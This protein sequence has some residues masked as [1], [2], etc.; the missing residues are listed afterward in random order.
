MYNC[1]EDEGQGIVSMHQFIYVELLLEFLRKMRTK[2]EISHNLSLPAQL[3]TSILQ[4]GTKSSTINIKILAF[5][6]TV[7]RKEP[8]TYQDRGCSS[9]GDLQWKDPGIEA[10]A[11]VHAEVGSDA[12]GDDDQARVPGVDGGV[13]PD[14]EVEERD[15]GCSDA[16]AAEERHAHGLLHAGEPERGQRPHRL[17][18]QH[19][20]GKG[21]TLLRHHRGDVR[22]LAAAGD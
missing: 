15:V 1:P 17:L 4:L 14:V 13:V 21:Q 18:D 9:I 16:Y 10:V 20:L 7:T 12:G 3:F 22:L 19:V 5:W 6:P 11:P 2:K 8:R